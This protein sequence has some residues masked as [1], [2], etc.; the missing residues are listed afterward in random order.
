[1]LATSLAVVR[2]MLEAVAG[3]AP[4]F[5]SVSG[6]SAPAMPLTVQRTIIETNTTRPNQSGC[7]SPCMLA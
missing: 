2:K 3:S 6:I 1:M 4:S 5:L 7:A